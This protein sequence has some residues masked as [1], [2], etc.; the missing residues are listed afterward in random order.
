MKKSMVILLAM[1]FAVQSWA[2]NV[3]DGINHFYAERYESA[4]G[5]FDRLIASNPNNLEA[6]YW[7]GQTHIRT[8]NVA[9]AKS[10]YERTLS[11]NGNAPLILAAMGHIDLLEGRTNEARQKFEGAITA[12][13]GKK[14]DD[15]MVL[16]AIGRA[17]VDAKA[18]DP[19][20]AIQKLS[21]AAETAN[22]PH[23]AL[24]LGNA[25]RKAGGRGGDAIQAYRKAT[26][27][28]PNFAVAYLRMADLY[29]TQRN[30][31]V[32]V[33]NLNSAIQA[34]AKFAPAYFDLYNYHLLYKRDYPTAAKFADQYIAV[35][36]P[37]VE[38]DY[39]KGYNSYI[40][41]NFD[42]AIGVAN[43]IL[44]KVG[45]KAN[46]RV[47][48]LLTYS[49]LG[50]GDTAT[51]CTN[52]GHFFA[53]ANDEDLIANDYIMQIDACGKNDPNAI[54]TALDMGLKQ[55]TTARGRFNF[56]TEV[57]ERAVKAKQ[58]VVEGEARLMIYNMRGANANPADLFYIGRPFYTGGAYLKADSIFK[59][60]SQA[61]PDSIYGY[62]YSARALALSDSGNVKGIAI[63]AYEKLL[64]VAERDRVRHKDIGIG[65]AGY[66]L[67]YYNNNKADRAAA[68]KYAERGLAFDPAHPNLLNAQKQLSTPVKGNS[69]PKNSGSTQKNN[70]SSN[71]AKGEGETETKVKTGNTKVK[72]ENGKTKV[73]KG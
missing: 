65:A 68:L 60:Y 13:R 17:N 20:Y 31:D 67:T 59:V 57:I 24:A 56:L 48:R 16:T 71:S 27:V 3:Q 4:K 64:E 63:P 7:L 70:T 54:R 1:F 8:K 10:L 69:A 23:L 55:D 50:K 30:W 33:E 51:A 66:L 73:K 62:Y 25:Y 12:S 32:V 9:A 2:Q 43:N 34:D 29:E 5:T 37:S 38:N 19:A 47:Y 28:A 42:A 72:T 44:S 46:P 26:Q 18:G 35:A 39:I 58:H 45:D 11:S 15:P 40:Q 49:Y 61:F 53:K 22:N 36:D 41:N 52:T 21:A 14:G 6:I